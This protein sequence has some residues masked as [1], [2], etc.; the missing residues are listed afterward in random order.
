[1]A[2]ASSISI[3]PNSCEDQSTISSPSR[4]RC[5]PVSAAAKQN[6]A[7]K[8]RSETA[9]IEFGAAAAK[10]SSAANCCGSIGSDEPASAPG[11]ER[12]DRRPHVPVAQPA[13]VPGE[14]LHV[15]EQLVGEQHRLRVLQVR[16]AG[17]G[18]V[19]ASPPP[20]RSAPSAARRAGRR[21]AARGRAGTAAGRWPPGRCGSGRPAACRRASRAARAAPARARCARPRRRS[22]AG[23]VPS[24]TASSRS[25]SAREHRV[26]LVVGQQPGPVQHPGVRAGREQVIPGEP[27]VEMHAERQPRERVRGPAL[28]P[29]APQPRRRRRR[30][31]ARPFPSVPPISLPQ[32]IGPVLPPYS[33]RRA[34]VA[35]KVRARAASRRRRSRTGARLRP[36]PPFPAASRRARRASCCYP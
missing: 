34:G 23:S 12:A 4:D 11:A 10:P 33:F 8:S 24:S 31:P 35:G 16:H 19:A 5:T 28:E 15:G 18:Q 20:A 36:H 3:Q 6:S 21:R 9:S 17:R 29:S 22:S 2:Y 14:R 32:C 13:H 1:M 7:A 26:G 25:S 27:P 30:S